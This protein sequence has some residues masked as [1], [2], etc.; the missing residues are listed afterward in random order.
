MSVDSSFSP[1]CRFEVH[2]FIDYLDIFNIMSLFLELFNSLLSFSK[3]CL[4]LLGMSMVIMGMSRNKIG[5][6]QSGASF[7]KFR[8]YFNFEVC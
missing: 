3:I 7:P 8:F 4:Q 2:L 5:S 6:I 1:F